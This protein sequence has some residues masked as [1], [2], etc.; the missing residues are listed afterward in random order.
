VTAL[1]PAPARRLLL[2]AASLNCL[3]MGTAQSLFGPAFE[4]L[5]LRFGIEVPAVSLIVSLH[6]LGAGVS[7]L[8]AGL[9]VMRFGYAWSCASVTR[10]C[11]PLPR[12]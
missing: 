1:P 5:A 3:V 6:F 12:D 11:S 10:G 2:L 8:A 7:I 9:L 4:P